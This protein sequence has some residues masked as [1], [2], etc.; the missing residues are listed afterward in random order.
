MQKIGN[1]DITINTSLWEINQTSTAFNLN[2]NDFILS[3]INGFE[4][5][6]QTVCPE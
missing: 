6:F 5:V 2:K 4:E 3:V 1:F